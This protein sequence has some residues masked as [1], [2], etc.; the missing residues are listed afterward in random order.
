MEAICQENYSDGTPS[1]LHT[2]QSSIDY[3]RG[4]RRKNPDSPKKLE[5]KMSSSYILKD[6]AIEFSSLSEPSESKVSRMVSLKKIDS[7][8]QFST[9]VQFIKPI[10]ITEEDSPC[11]VSSEKQEKIKKFFAGSAKQEK[12]A[13]GFKKKEENS[14]IREKFY[15]DKQ[16]KF[17]TERK[18]LMKVRE[19]I[20]EL[21]KN[22]EKL[23]E[24]ADGLRG[25]LKKIEE[26]DNEGAFTLNSIET[27]LE[28]LEN[29]QLIP[30]E[31]TRLPEAMQKISN[32]ESEILKLKKIKDSSVLHYEEQLKDVYIKLK[33]LHEC[34]EILSEMVACFRSEPIFIP[35]DLQNAETFTEDFKMEEIGTIKLADLGNSEAILQEANAKLSQLQETKA[36]LESEYKSIPNDS[37]SMISKRRKLALEFEL[38]LNYSQ[39][40]SIGNKIKRYTN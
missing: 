4:V 9:K 20:S 11:S 37:K 5:I 21:R 10:Q 38:S 8:S 1:I 14:L 13:L 40:V 36:K 35:K 23:Q 28:K 29:Q 3:V 16:E 39:L 15:E 12:P 33:N 26:I 30:E 18:M 6:R 2:L 27:K 7:A 17:E 31:D 22:K 19:E 24:K 32:L 25:S 34:N